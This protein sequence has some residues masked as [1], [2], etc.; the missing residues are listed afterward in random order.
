MGV[1]I[2]EC[3]ECRSIGLW[4]CWIIS[5]WKLQHVRSDSVSLRSIRTLG[6]CTP[7]VT[8]CHVMRMEQSYS[9]INMKK[10]NLTY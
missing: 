8:G 6:F 5:L 1:L 9:T 10:G 3:R 4:E 2:L 7:A